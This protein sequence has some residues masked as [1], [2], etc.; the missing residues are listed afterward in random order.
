LAISGTRTALRRI[1]FQRCCYLFVLLLALIAI[2]PFLEPLSHGALIMNA[3]NA[4]LIV[5]AVAA[6][7]R[8]KVSF[9]IATLLAIPALFFHWKLAQT[10][11]TTY[12]ELWLKCGLALY[13]VTIFFL[14]RY[15]FESGVMSADRLSGAA[16]GYLMM[17]VMWTFIYALVTRADPAAFSA[18]GSRA[19]L[20]FMDL[21]YYS[22]T[23]LTTMGYGD[24]VPM[25]RA[26]RTAAIM[27]AIIGQ[28]FLAILIAKLVSVYPIPGAR[29]GG[30]AK[31]DLRAD[32]E[33]PDD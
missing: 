6:V 8:S 10:G 20:P 5:S 30:P 13:A 25:S 3:I 21:L 11:S 23:T 18:A 24:I 15:V 14:L 7:G 26:A 32:G 29:S 4:F 9:V 22:F 28:L 27:E 19:P 33:K 16:S 31:S 2:P 12:H 1:F 17:G